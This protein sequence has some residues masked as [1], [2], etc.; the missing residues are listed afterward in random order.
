MLTLEFDQVLDGCVFICLSVD[1]HG[2]DSLA[3]EIFV[4]LSSCLLSD[5]G[6]FG[7]EGTTS[8]VQPIW[9]ERSKAE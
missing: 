8:S 7:C 2:D 6:L 4:M 9:H 3:E 1:A 5:S